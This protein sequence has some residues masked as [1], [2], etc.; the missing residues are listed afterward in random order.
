[1]VNGYGWLRVKNVLC[2]SVKIVSKRYIEVKDYSI[3]I[4]IIRV[5]V[6]I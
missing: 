4:I 1:M 2:Y 3:Y 6:S 5:I